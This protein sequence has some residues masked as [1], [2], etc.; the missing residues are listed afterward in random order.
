[1]CTHSSVEREPRQFHVKYDNTPVDRRVGGESKTRTT[2]KNRRWRQE[3]KNEKKKIGM[4]NYLGIIFSYT[5][6]SHSAYSC[7]CACVYILLSFFPL[8]SIFLY[9]SLFIFHLFPPHFKLA[10]RHTVKSLNRRLC[11]LGVC[12][13]VGG[14]RAQCT[15]SKSAKVHGIVK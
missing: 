3:K 4:E 13:W 8:H 10:V 15:E 1:M 6:E 12:V 11:T 7:V 2:S 14:S 9:S 5:W